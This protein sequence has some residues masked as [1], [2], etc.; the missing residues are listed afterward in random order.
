MQIIDFADENTDYRIKYGIDRNK[1]LT[2][3]VGE[4]FY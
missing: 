1:K 3:Y 4:V 2:F